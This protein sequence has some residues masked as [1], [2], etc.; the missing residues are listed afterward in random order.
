MNNKLLNY[1]AFILVFS[2]GSSIEVQDCSGFDVKS[3]VQL[4]FGA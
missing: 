2:Y 4:G 3:L 1:F